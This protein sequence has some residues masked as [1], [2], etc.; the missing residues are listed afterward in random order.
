M[1]TSKVELFE[2]GLQESAIFFKALGHPARLMIL[3]FLTENNSCFTGD[4]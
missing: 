3:K 4:I 1:P 2:T